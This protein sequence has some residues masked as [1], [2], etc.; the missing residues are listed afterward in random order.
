MEWAFLR[1][2][3]LSLWAILGI[4]LLLSLW[5]NFVLPMWWSPRCIR[6]VFE[7]QKIPCLP[8]PS[9]Y[10]NLAQ[11]SQLSRTATAHP[12][13]TISHD[14]GPRIMP[15]LYEWSKTYGESVFSI[16]FSIA[17]MLLKNRTILS[18]V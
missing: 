8:S 3:V 7:K 13:P 11:I 1:G 15:H 6:K 2:A 18:C 12:M 16:H 10:G 5:Q 4:P 17:A 14:I 9:L